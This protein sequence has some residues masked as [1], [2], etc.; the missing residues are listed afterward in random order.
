MELCGVRL[1]KLMGWEGDGSAVDAVGGAAQAIIVTSKSGAARN[2]GAKV[3]RVTRRGN[4]R[5]LLCGDGV[6]ALGGPCLD[7]APMNTRISTFVVTVALALT[8]G[9]CG[10]DL[11]KNPDL[12]GSDGFRQNAEEI[13]LGTSVIGVVDAKS[14]DS[15]DWKYFVTPAIGVPTEPRRVLKG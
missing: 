7:P 4:F 15:N 8:A 1:P 2:I 13:S 3:Q 10:H 14:G 12:P 9:T 5:A 11:E 6:D